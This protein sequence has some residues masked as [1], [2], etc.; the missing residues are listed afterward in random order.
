MCLPQNSK[1]FCI[2]SSPSRTSRVCSASPTAIGSETKTFRVA[3]AA[4]SASARAASSR[5]ISIRSASARS[6]SSRSASRAASKR[7]AS[8]R[9]RRAASSA[10]TR[11]A[12]LREESGSASSRNRA[13]NELM[14]DE[15]PMC[16]LQNSAIFNRWSSPLKTSRKYS[17]PFTCT[18]SD[19]MSSGAVSTNSV[20]T[21]RCNHAPSASEKST[22]RPGHNEPPSDSP[23]ATCVRPFSTAKPMAKPCARPNHDL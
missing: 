16:T 20:A 23:K 9:A 8:S 14:Q 11:S 12:S 15:S 2:G 1:S 22:V 21:R 10:A 6:A 5:W 17:L 13:V 7:S 19:T 3:A 4:R 18:G